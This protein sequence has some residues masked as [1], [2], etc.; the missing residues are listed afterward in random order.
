MCNLMSVLYIPSSLRNEAQK[1]TGNAGSHTQGCVATSLFPVSPGAKSVAHPLTFEPSL[2]RECQL[3]GQLHP[4]LTSE[5]LEANTGQRQA[6]S[7]CVQ[8]SAE[9]PSG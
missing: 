7:S 6:A 1:P 5:A 4:A 2:L 9:V 3:T 8:I